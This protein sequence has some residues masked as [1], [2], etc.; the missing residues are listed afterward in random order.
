MITEFK[1]KQ[2]WLDAVKA[3]GLVVEYWGQSSMD[4]YNDEGKSTGRWY[5][6]FDCNNGIN[7]HGWLKNY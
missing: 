6:K 3:R 7:P 1:D 2:E 4:A 5:A